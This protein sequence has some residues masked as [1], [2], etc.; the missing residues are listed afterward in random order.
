[1]SNQSRSS[2][3][4]TTSDRMRCCTWSR[5]SLLISGDEN[6]AV[7]TEET[8]AGLV[9]TD[10]QKNTVYVVAKRSKSTTPEDFGVEI[11][12]SRPL[13]RATRLSEAAR[14]RSRAAVRAQP[15]C[16]AR[17]AG[18]PCECLVGVAGAAVNGWL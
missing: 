3:K 18:A 2:E 12:S 14:A 7:F 9:A 16:H 4:P 8:N 5:L 13:G 15:R 1:M 17:A 11:V 10:T 6:S